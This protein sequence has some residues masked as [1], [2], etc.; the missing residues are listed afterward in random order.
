MPPLE[1]G[2]EGQV[3]VVTGGGRS[4]GRAC[5]VVLAEM[6]ANVVLCGRDE[7]LF[8]KGHQKTAGLSEK[9]AVRFGKI[10]RA[11]KKRSH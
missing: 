3:A 7:A 4:I 1:L 8:R 2:L 6:G 10:T 9:K 11:G 5:S